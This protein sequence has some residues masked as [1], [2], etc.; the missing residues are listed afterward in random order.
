MN[1]GREVSLSYDVIVVTAGAVTRALPVPGIAEAAFGLKHVEE[2]V[3]IRDAFLTALDQAAA[4]S[5]GPAR[6][7]ALTV[8]FI[9]GGFAGVEGFG[10]L[11]SLSRAALKRYPQISPDE[12]S[13][14][15]VEA[16][17][18]ILPEVS[19]KTGAWV[20]RRRLGP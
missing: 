7:K 10:E 14:H 17:Y 16:S 12:L 15:L 13:F 19:A 4:M 3:A 11:L 6:R 18:R 8:T 20:V 9:G 5:E 2:A 1:D